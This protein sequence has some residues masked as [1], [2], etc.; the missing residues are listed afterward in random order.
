MQ[1][2]QDTLR[3]THQAVFLNNSFLGGFYE[4]SPAPDQSNRVTFNLLSD[5]IRLKLSGAIAWFSKEK[6]CVCQDFFLNLHPA[7]T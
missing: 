5:S 3:P 6:P 1:K 4:L 7:I 2:V